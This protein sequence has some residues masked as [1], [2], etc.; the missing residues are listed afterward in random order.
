[1]KEEIYEDIFGGNFSGG[2]KI[3]LDFYCEEDLEKGAM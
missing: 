2:G 3:I 1:M